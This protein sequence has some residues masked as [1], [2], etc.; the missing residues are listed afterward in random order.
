VHTGG[1][2]PG[3]TYSWSPKARLK[4]SENII[5]SNLEGTPESAAIGKSIA[6]TSEFICC[7]A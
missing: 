3:G 1:G 5:V 7:S 6:A 4:Y 2:D